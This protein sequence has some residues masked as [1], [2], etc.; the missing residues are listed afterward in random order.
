MTVR[1]TAVSRCP[2]KKRSVKLELRLVGLS[3][4]TITFTTI[5]IN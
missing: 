2:K 5:N 3:I 1:G 4:S